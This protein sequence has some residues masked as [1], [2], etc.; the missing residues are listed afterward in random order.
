MTESLSSRP[1]NPVPARDHLDQIRHIT[2]LL[3]KT[4]LSTRLY[5]RNNQVY[6][7]FWDDLRASLTAFLTAHDTLRLDVGTDQLRVDGETVYTPRD[8]DDLFTYRLYKDGLREIEFN[9]GLSDDELNRFLEIITTDFDRAEYLEQDLVSLIWES[10]FKHIRILSVDAF[11]EEMTEDD[12]YFTEVN[13]VFEDLEANELANALQKTL[14]LHVLRL[15]T[16]ERAEYRDVSGGMASFEECGALNA[17][18]IYEISPAAQ[19]ALRQ[20]VSALETGDEAAYERARW[21]LFEIFRQCKDEDW[22][23]I[24]E[25]MTKVIHASMRD[26]ELERALQLLLPIHI[27]SCPEQSRAFNNHER[28]RGFIRQLGSRT[29]LHLLTPH[30]R[31][32]DWIEA[33]RSALFSFVSLLPAE[34]IPELIAWLD[35]LE[36]IPTYRPVL[37]GLILIAENDWTPFTALLRSRRAPLVA[38]TIQ[39]LGRLA[40]PQAYEVILSAAGHESP[41]V[42]LELLTALQGNQSPR[43]REHIARSVDDTDPEIRLTALRLA[44]VN[45]NRQAAERI[46]AIM[47][48]RRFTR[49]PFRELKALTM[50][51][52]YIRGDEAQSVLLTLFEDDRHPDVQR[53]TAHAL[54]VLGGPDNRR[55]LESAA[56]NA[57]SPLARECA[58]VLRSMNR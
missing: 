19:T 48:E 26:G 49:L 41:R 28:V 3:S 58:Q 9:R 13:A 50:A 45:R 14:E 39:S 25:G 5:D 22:P 38:E 34:C 2:S 4:A 47:Q 57:S 42:R 21:I 17:H 18:R 37:D 44:A 27:L 52:A 55:V 30:L 15:D 23:D 8:E 43:A 46:E 6:R 54:G 33:N 12:D 10:D 32:K 11:V 40:D 20:E 16:E 7:R 35:E 56:R 24:E 53:A 29:S 36:S 51:L 1:P 31:S